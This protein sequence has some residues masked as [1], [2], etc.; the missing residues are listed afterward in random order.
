MAKRMKAGPL[1]E[2]LIIQSFKDADLLADPANA[3]LQ[4]AGERPAAARRDGEEQTASRMD[5]E[6]PAADEAAVPADGTAKGKSRRRKGS[7]DEVYLKRRELKTRQPVYISQEIH[8]SVIKL[9]HLLALAGKEISVGGYIDNV[10]AEHLRQH[11]DEIAE[12]Y[13]SGIDDILQTDH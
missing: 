13:R 6:E 8:R 1:D 11:K 10:L 2:S 4:G 9:V 3:V 12:L 7:Y 5:G